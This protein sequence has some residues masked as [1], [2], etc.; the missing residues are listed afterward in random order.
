[1]DLKEL[2]EELRG[3]ILRDI[4]TAVPADPSSYLWSDT[5]LVRYINDA[6]SKFARRTRCLRD[7]TT[8]EVV[9]IALEEGVEFYALHKSVIGVMSAKLDGSPL[10]RAADGPLSGSPGDVAMGDRTVQG[11][12][13]G[14]PVWYSTDESV[15]TLRLTPIPDA[16]IDGAVVRLRVERLPL[17]ALSVSDKTAAPELQEDYH[18]DLLEWAAFKAL[19]NHD[20]DGENM[21]KA[22]THRAAFNTAVEEAARD[23]KTQALAPVQFGVKAR[24]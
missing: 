7:S 20:V 23:I 1:M 9:E 10:R 14:R 8:A 6:Q 4:S 3:N 13:G 21:Q 5:T 16:S 17:V 15:S 24:Y 12:N 18:L 22:N 19:R 11:G 2:L